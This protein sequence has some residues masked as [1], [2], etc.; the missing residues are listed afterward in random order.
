MDL[1]GSPSVRFCI[2]FPNVMIPA[3]S[4][5]GPGGPV[6]SRVIAETLIGQA[7]LPW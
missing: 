1:V 4:S 6:D 3:A 5:T 2:H 7:P